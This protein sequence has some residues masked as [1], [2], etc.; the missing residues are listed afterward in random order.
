MLEGTRRQFSYYQQKSTWPTI[1]WRTFGGHCCWNSFPKYLMV[2]EDW[3]FNSEFRG[4]CREGLLEDGPNN[5]KKCVWL[6]ENSLEILMQISYHK[7][8]TW[9]RFSSIGKV[10]KNI[11][12]SL[13]ICESLKPSFHCNIFSKLAFL[14]KYKLL[15]LYY[16]AQ[17]WYFVPKNYSFLDKCRTISCKLVKKYWTSKKVLT[18]IFSFTGIEFDIFQNLLG[19]F[20]AKFP[21]SS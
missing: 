3:C 10:K 6:E 21:V 14:L 18:V 17:R 20:L 15:Q 13:V 8:M 19:K 5:N 12:Y 9:N 2:T 1:H 16:G 4:R 11:E 7:W